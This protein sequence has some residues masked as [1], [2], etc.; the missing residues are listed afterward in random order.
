[1]ELSDAVKEYLA[2]EGYDPIFGAR[3]L[4]RLIQRKVL[5]ALATEILQGHVSED[6]R[7]VADMDTAGEGEV[8]FHA[9]GRKRR[10]S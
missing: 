10:K 6:D 5:D 4:K 2:R 3:P 9:P 7:V 1:M 8:M